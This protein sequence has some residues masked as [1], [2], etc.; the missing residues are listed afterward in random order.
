MIWATSPAAT[1]LETCVL[2]WMAEMMGMPEK[3]RSTSEGGGVIQDTAS[4]SALTAVV[5]AR[6]RVTGFESIKQEPGRT[7]WPMFPL[8]HI[9]RLKRL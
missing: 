2:D 3:F 5:A 7:W 6:E 1:E 4:T 8:K 9:L